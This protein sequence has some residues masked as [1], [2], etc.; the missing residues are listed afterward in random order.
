MK[1]TIVGL[2]LI[3]TAHT[4]V[5]EEGKLGGVPY[6]S[7]TVNGEQHEIPVINDTKRQTLYYLKRAIEHND[8]V[9]REMI[10]AGEDSQVIYIGNLAPK[11]LEVTPSSQRVIEPGG[12]DG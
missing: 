12:H 11:W 7:L 1:Y 10:L 6:V 3:M 9:A 5:A 2:L 4:A 8:V